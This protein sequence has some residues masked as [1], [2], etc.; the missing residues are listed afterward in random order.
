[1]MPE[2]RIGNV[3]V[4]S[5]F[6]RM[7]NAVVQVAGNQRRHDLI[8]LATLLRQQLCASADTG[9]LPVAVQLGHQLLAVVEPVGDGLGQ[10]R[11]CG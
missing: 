6:T 7:Q 8:A 9:S 1:M 2:R 4:V 3:R 11:H 5:V 10:W